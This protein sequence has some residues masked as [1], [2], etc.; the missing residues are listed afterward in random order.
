MHITHTIYTVP[1]P[2]TKNPQTALVIHD[3][4][5]NSVTLQWFGS[6]PAG[7]VATVLYR[8]TGLDCHVE[9]RTFAK[10]E[11]ESFAKFIAQLTSCPYRD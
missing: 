8:H 3:P 4:N 6:I 9:K 1:Q 2:E 11:S 10:P 7:D 5:R